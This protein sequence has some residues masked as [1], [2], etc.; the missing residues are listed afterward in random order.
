[1]GVAKVDEQAPP[2]VVGNIAVK[3]LDHLGTRGVVGQHDR[4][5]VFGVKPPGQ[6]GRVNQITGQ[7]GELAAGG[8]EGVRRGCSHGR[9]LGAHL[10]GDWDRGGCGD[11]RGLRGPT[12]LDQRGH[13][14]I[15]LPPACLNTPLRPTAVAHGLAHGL[16]D[17]FQRSIADK[18]V[19]PHLLL[20]LLLGDHTV[21]MAQ[22]IV[23]HLKYF[24]P[25]WDGQ[26]SP[27]HDIELRVQRTV[28]EDIPHTD[29]PSNS[30]VS[31]ASAHQGE[32][33]SGGATSR[34]VATASAR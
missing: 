21:A 34:V 22:E 16:Q 10:G 18:L 7:H 5:P 3:A 12:R 4:M 28:P 31:R 24:G 9:R 8:G 26:P 33:V 23:Q 14:A 30:A 17:A 13:K 19:G 11:F 1:M 29:V 32:R 27:L 20:Q 25:Q 6:C 15:A 2:E